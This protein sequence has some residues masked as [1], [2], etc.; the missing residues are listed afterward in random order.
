MMRV[1]CSHCGEKDGAPCLSVLVLCVALSLP[2]F[3][4]E[5]PAVA[6][7]PR[8]HVTKIGFLAPCF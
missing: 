8:R 2:E 7:H 4:S 5:Q 1:L 3:L 6:L